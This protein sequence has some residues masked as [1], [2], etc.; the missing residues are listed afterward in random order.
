MNCGMP[1]AVVSERLGHADQN[2]TLSIYSHAMP[3]DTRAALLVLQSPQR[4]DEFRL[5]MHNLYVLT[6]YNRNVF[7][8]VAV[9]DLAEALRAA[10]TKAGA[11]R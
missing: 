4:P 3:A 8:G 11:A 6:R 7:Y 10:R 5:G 2:I 9:S 1:I